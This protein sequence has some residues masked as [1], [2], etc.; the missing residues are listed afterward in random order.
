MLALLRP[1]SWRRPPQ[2]PLA[3]LTP[4]VDESAKPRRRFDV[5]AVIVGLLL[6]VLFGRMVHLQLVVAPE[7]RD[8]AAGNRI[9]VIES[10]APRGRLLDAAGRV[11]AGS[12]TSYDVMLDWQGLAELG[13]EERRRAL[14]QAADELVAAGHRTT[15]DE[16]EE[17][18]ALARR[19]SL[20]P[21]V[22]VPDVGVEVWVTLS[23]RGLPGFD[24]V[25]NPV[26]T[27]PNGTVA[28]HVLGYMG[29]VVDDEE[30]V[31]LNRL[32]PGHT[33][34]AG[35]EIGR[36]GLERLLERHLRGVP[37]V[38]RVE[39]DSANRV[40][41]TVDITQ[42]ARPGHDVRLTIDLDLQ[43]LAE[44]SLGAELE[45]LQAADVPATAGSFIVIDPRDGAVP[46]L[47]SWPGFDPGVFID[48]LGSAEAERL[49]ADPG[50][51]FLNRAIGGLY[52]AA[53]TF[54]PVTAY[55]SLTAG[56]RQPSELWDDQGVYEL[57]SCR[58]S[59]DQGCRFRNARGAVLGSVDLASAIALSSDTF[60]YSLGERL[61]LERASLGDD[62]LQQAANRFGLGTVTGVEL[63]GEASGHVPTPSARQ[64]QHDQAPEAFP[65]PRWYTGD[66]VNLAI[67]QGEL[68]VTPIQL[69]N[70]YASIA[71][72]GVRHQPRLV[73]RVIDG[74]TGEIVL[75]FGTRVA[76]PD[77]LAPEI[78]DPIVD[79][80]GGA[81]TRGT[82]ATAFAGF[83]LD[84][85]PLAVKT[86]T[87][88]VRGKRDFALFA[89]FG[90]RD[91]PRYA[92][93][94]VIEEAGFGGEAAAPV[95]RHFLDGA[96][97][98]DQQDGQP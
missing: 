2:A 87:A 33:Y 92:F 76:E 50:D 91:E 37:E 18:F 1:R 11:L 13:S 48:R 85:V 5:V 9:R 61:W 72:G 88:E 26:R 77:L 59:G 67:G 29:S 51:P 71:A 21:V 41:R 38:R 23:E 8:I 95:A 52:P 64:L 15:A 22:V 53:S 81:A 20:E 93:A 98:I 74:V 19:Q 34:R 60:F 82:A 54:K 94:V 16:L 57:A 10:P 73:D 86:G 97:L 63:P 80:L 42:P 58:G 75:E 14:L 30:A 31:R 39:V 89:G 47:V 79:G 49:F 27:Y 96:L 70:L 83:P 35:S 55:A 17:R 45:R 62:A 12:R 68:L 7:F 90:P 3:G 36:S 69:A 43:R 32:D 78:L 56:L 4:D 28:A 65:D 6:L 66:S 44:E 84:T 25:A 24:V 40:V 46:A